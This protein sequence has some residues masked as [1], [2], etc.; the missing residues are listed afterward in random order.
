M[1]FTPEIALEYLRRSHALGR[2]GHAEPR[3]QYRAD[4]VLGRHDAWAYRRDGVAG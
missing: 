2:L 1:A 4:A 3:R